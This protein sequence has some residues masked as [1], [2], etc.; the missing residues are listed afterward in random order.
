[1]GEPCGP[2]DDVR[3]AG[4]SSAKAAAT[5]T[6]SGAVYLDQHQPLNSASGFFYRAPFFES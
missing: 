5:A 2:E 3:T 6:R 4:A 1:M